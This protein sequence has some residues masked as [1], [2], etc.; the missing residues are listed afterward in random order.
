[1]RSCCFLSMDELGSYVTDDDLAIEPLRELGWD[2]K[3]VSWRKKDIDWTEF[4]A[5]VIRTPWDYHKEPQAFLNVLREIE[6]SG[7]RLENSLKI[8]EW[9]LCKTYLREIEQ[10]GVTIV[11]TIFGSGLIDDGLVKGWLEKLST[12]EIIIKPVISATARH[13]YR[14]KEYSTDIAEIFREQKYM[15]QT[16]MRNIVTEGEFSLFYFGGEYSHSILKTP[17][18]DD[19]RVQEDFGGTNEFI[20][21]SR[22]LLRSGKRVLDVITPTPLY[23]RVDLVRNEADEFALMELELIEPA[24]YF[25]VDKESPRRF[26]KMF[27]KRMNE[28]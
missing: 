6:N 5:V 12:D 8:V 27:N 1:M 24:L 14:I 26:A 21:P 2:V 3:F 17:K 23:A 10:N 16:Y 7:V 22:K 4:E 25:R 13:T 28:L 15:V 19:F 18:Q 20:E 9:N 11:P